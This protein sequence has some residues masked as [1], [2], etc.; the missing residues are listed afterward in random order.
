MPFFGWRGMHV[1]VI[2]SLQ[3]Y[4]EFGFDRASA[5][6]IWSPISSARDMLLQRMNLGT[7]ITDIGVVQLPEPNRKLFDARLHRIGRNATTLASR[8]ELLAKR[9]GSIVSHI[10]YP[11]LV[12][13]PAHT[14]NKDRSFHGGF[15]SIVFKPPHRTLSGYDKFIRDVVAVAKKRSIDIV[16][17]TTFGFTTTRIYIPA[18]LTEDIEQAYVRVSAGTETTIEI[19]KLVDVFSEVMTR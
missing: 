11:G 9:E 16:V 19:E 6:V 15:F 12:S 4:H 1:V 3:K 2:E 17:G 10:A 7:N 14:W 13:H 5:G 18:R 8:L